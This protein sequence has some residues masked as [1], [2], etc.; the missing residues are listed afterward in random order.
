[1]FWIIIVLFSLAFSVFFVSQDPFRSGIFHA[2][3]ALTTTGFSTVSSFSEISK[4]LIIILMVIG[5][6]AG[7][8]AGGLKLIRIGILSNIFSWLNRKITSPLSAVIPFKFDKKMIGESEVT[9]LS[10]YTLIYILI[11]VVSALVIGLYGY[12]LSDS[13]FISASAQGTTGLSTIDV[14]PMT[15]VCK[16]VLMI[17]ML[18][19]RLEI[20][21]FMVLFYHI[22][23][24]FR[25]KS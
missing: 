14:Y 4:F 12:S 21:P 2:F 10:L 11:L 7:S 17:D 6:Y 19:G 22:F 16:F 20:L 3:S 8:T 13:I 15:F 18:F 24:G 5:G 1:M 25:R 23:S 9:I